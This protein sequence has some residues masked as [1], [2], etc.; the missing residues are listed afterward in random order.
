M[1]IGVQI[2]SLRPGQI[3]G[4][5][6]SVRR[7]L[8]H[9]V[10]KLGDDRLVLL[11]RPELAHEPAAQALCACSAV[12]AVVE[13]PE[14]HYGD[15]YAAWNL[16]VLE[17]AA[18]DVVYFPLSFF[19]P[20]PLPLPVVLHVPDIQHEYFPEYFPPDQLAWRRERIPESIA[21]AEAVIT[22]TQFSAHGLVEKLGVEPSRLH[23]IPAG[24]FPQD[25]IGPA[26]DGG[27]RSKVGPG[28][29]RSHAGAR[30]SSSLASVPME[31]GPFIFYPAADWPHK[32]HETLL[33]AMALL[34]E[35]G[36]TEQLVLTGI[37]SQRGDELR[38]ITKELGLTERVHF[39]GHVSQDELIGLYRG[40]E[41]MAFPS[42]FEG[43]GLPLVE[44]MQLGCP[45]VASR[46][47]AVVET[48]GNA[49]VFCND[50]P[51]A[52]AEV[53]AT[54]LDNAALRSD[55]RRRGYERAARFD[56]N[57]CAEE[58]LAL[59]RRLGRP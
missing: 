12:E 47:E 53:L 52:W 10:P 33:R 30:A 39:P 5:G 27:G 4:Q 2:L 31:L 6:V 40:A 58:H 29:D 14:R 51:E 23:V 36:R 45:I 21:L 48:A 20:R 7:L 28:A 35:R 55:L 54:V 26:E 1:R 49:A 9:L 3:G 50:G 41:L 38:M 13:E 24:G 46:A 43:F 18:L 17:R 16:Q 56:W 57:R 32:N 34:A 37:L 42:R 44:A 25:E 59:L 8:Q 11:M 15:G 19:Y 22:Y